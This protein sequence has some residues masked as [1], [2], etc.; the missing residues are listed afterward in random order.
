MENNNGITGKKKVLRF[1]AMRKNLFLLFIAVMLATPSSARFNAFNSNAPAIHIGFRAGVGASEYGNLDRPE[2]LATPIGGMHLDF[3]VSSIPLYVETGA[4]YMDM[5]TRFRNRW[6]SRIRKDDDTNNYYGYNEGI[7]Y[8]EIGRAYY[9]SSGSDRWEDG[10]RYTVHNHSVL[11]PLALSYHLYV[12][13]DIVIKPFTGFYG[14]YGFTSEEM[15][16][17][18]HDGVGVSFGHFDIS[19]GLNVGLLE[20]RQKK[21]KVWVEDARHVSAFFAVGIYF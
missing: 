8:D 4:Y 5:G 12:S 13:D 1:L 18:L 19:L 16:F 2:V 3:K 6:Y 15:D 20:Q 14:S 17:G 11:V 10:N 7:R 21:D 9:Y